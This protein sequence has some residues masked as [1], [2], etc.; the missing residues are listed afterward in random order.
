MDSCLCVGDVWDI[1]AAACGA[2]ADTLREGAGSS[3]HVQS[4]WL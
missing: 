1:T 3:C 4:C 2:L